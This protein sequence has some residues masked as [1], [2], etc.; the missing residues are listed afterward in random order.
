MS[1]IKGDSLRIHVGRKFSTRDEDNDVHSGLSCATNH[2]GAWWYGHCYH[3]NLNGHYYRGVTTS[4]DGVAWYH[5]R[6][7][8]Y[9]LKFTEMKLRPFYV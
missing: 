6:G 2:K 4:D 3:A 5:W 9:S 8:R 7:Y 1:A